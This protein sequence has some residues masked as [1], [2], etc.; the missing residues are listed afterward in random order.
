MSE[1]DAPTTLWVE[2]EVNIRQSEY[3]DYK[4]PRG[5]LSMRFPVLESEIHALAEQAPAIMRGL[6]GG[7]YQIYLADVVKKAKEDVDESEAE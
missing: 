6:V 1:K 4:K 7:S 2:F 3:S 5:D